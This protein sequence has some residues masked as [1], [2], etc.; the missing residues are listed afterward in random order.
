[1]S[2]Q[3][4]FNESV[5][6]PA[7]LIAAVAAGNFKA[8][9]RALESGIPAD[10]RDAA[11]NTALMLAV[12]GRNLLVAGMLLGYGAGVSDEKLLGTALMH[13]SNDLTDLLLE[14]GADP[15]PHMNQSKRL[16]TRAVVRGVDTAV[17]ALLANKADKEAT[18]DKGASLLI[19]AAENDQ[20]KVVDILLKAGI[21]V[22]KCDNQGRS[23]LR[24]AMQGGS[25]DCVNLLLAAGADPGVRCEFKDRSITDHEF[26]KQCDPAIV[27]AID[28]A[29][30][31]FRLIDAA[32]E[33]N[34]A[35]VTRLLAK[36]VSVNTFDHQGVTA[37]TCACAQKHALI[38]KMLLDH[39]TDP[40]LATKKMEAPL[41][42]S[43]GKGDSASTEM[44][45]ASGAV[46]GPVALHRACGGKYANVVRI[47]LKHGADPNVTARNAKVFPE[48]SDFMISTALK[49]LPDDYPLHTAIKHND[50]ESV[51]ALAAAGASTLVANAEGKTPLQLAWNAEGQLILKCVKERH[52]EEMEQMGRSATQLNSEMG[53]MKTLRFKSKAGPS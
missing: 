51:T 10:S 46:P 23:A 24:A 8:A 9:R 49:V 1:M 2:L 45:L 15:L 26:S 30:D 42:I 7:G 5:T 17:K 3:Q 14:S 13:D 20:E 44:L 31:K 6:T 19:L 52:D 18:D 28:A 53:A 11:G 16:L 34:E 21:D 48:P 35:E 37:L 39:K 38:V 43:V 4:D 41:D 27:Q 33:G 32:S 22:H 47:L 29:Y 25:L 40:N 36:D 12:Q 50:F